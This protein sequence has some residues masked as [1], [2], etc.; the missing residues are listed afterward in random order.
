MNLIRYKGINISFDYGKVV[1]VPS[2][3]CWIGNGIIVGTQEG[4]V[5][6]YESKKSKWKAKSTHSVL[7]IKSYNL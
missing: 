1:G 2:A 3:L 4:T 5:A 6:Y 7:S